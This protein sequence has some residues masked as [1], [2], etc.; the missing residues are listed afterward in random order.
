MAAVSPTPLTHGIK[1]SLDHTGASPHL[2]SPPAA[3]RIHPRPSPHA[4]PGAHNPRRRLVCHGTPPPAPPPWHPVPAAALGRRDP[5]GRCRQSCQVVVAGSG[6]AAGAAGDGARPSK[7]AV[8]R[9]PE[10]LC[11]ELEPRGAG[12]PVD[13]LPGWRSLAR[14]LGGWATVAAPQGAGRALLGD[15]KEKRRALAER[16]DRFHGRRQIYKTLERCGEGLGQNT[17]HHHRNTRS[18]IETT[19]EWKTPSPA[20]QKTGLPRAGA[21]WAPWHSTLFVLILK[22]KAARG[23]SPQPA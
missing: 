20:Q 12:M 16:H 15:G 17:L 1:V 2:P 18:F 19:G 5:P 6:G 9:T 8:G 13:P 11:R 21:R 3:P 4:Q 22:G 7:P 14:G 23:H 10:G